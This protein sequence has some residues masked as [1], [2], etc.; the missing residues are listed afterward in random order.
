MTGVQTCALPI[1]QPTPV[2]CAAQVG[3]RNLHRSQTEIM[4]DGS[5]FLL[6][7]V[8]GSTGWQYDQCSRV[9]RLGG[10][11][12]TET[13]GDSSGPVTAMEEVVSLASLKSNWCD[14]EAL[15][16]TE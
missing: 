15:P 11:S 12:S 10:A 2:Q 9:A 14:H 4:T 5:R 16:A 8:A 1:L 13:F 7:T 3:E 6:T